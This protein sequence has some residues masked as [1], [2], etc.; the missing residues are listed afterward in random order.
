M[1]CVFVFRILL[2]GWAGTCDGDLGARPLTMGSTKHA[3]PWWTG[4]NGGPGGGLIVL[5]LTCEPNQPKSY[6]YWDLP[7]GLSSR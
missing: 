6:S 5:A 7:R 2:E 4:A 1:F 3:D